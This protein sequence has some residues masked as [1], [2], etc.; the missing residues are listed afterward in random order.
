LKITPRNFCA[1]SI[2]VSLE[3]EG[4]AERCEAKTLTVHNEAAANQ[5]EE[6]GTQ[7]SFPGNVVIFENL[8]ACT[9]HKVML[10]VFLNKR[11]AT[12]I[13]SDFHFRPSV[14]SFH[15][16]PSY[17][18][19][20]K[21][22]FVQYDD[23]TRNFSWN[24][25]KFF[26]QTCAG[27]L[28]FTGVQMIR[29]GETEKYDGPDGSSDVVKDCNQEASLVVLFKEADEEKSVVALSQT[30]LRSSTPPE[31]ERVFVDENDILQIIRDPCLSSPSIKLVPNDNKLTPKRIP[32]EKP[33]KMSEVAWEGCIDYSVEVTRSETTNWPTLSH[34]GWKNLL[35]DWSLKVDAVDDKSITFRPLEK[36][37]EVETI[38]LEIDCDGRVHANKKFESNQWAEGLLVEQVISG[39]EY[40]CRARLLNTE[41]DKEVPG[42]WTKGT[43]VNTTEEVEVVKRGPMLTAGDTTGGEETGEKMDSAAKAQEGAAGVAPTA[44]GIGCIC[45]IVALAVLVVWR[46]MAGKKVEPNPLL[47]D[48]NDP[49]E[50]L[51]EVL[52][53]S[54]EEVKMVEEREPGSGSD[55]MKDVSDPIKSDP[56][57]DQHGSI[58]GALELNAPHVDAR[59]A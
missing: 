26:E 9:K 54:E 7:I 53:S 55:P 4:A 13:A 52:V 12:T 19:L 18:D 31:Q 30:V 29:D 15:T 34:P 35:A 1:R 11:E 45:V 49:D 8:Q 32:F 50:N 33:I 51:S 23:T 22:E 3:P 43:R 58:V 14:A 37:C 17:N 2:G 10:D 46:G 25:T 6:A 42:A 41:G 59:E 48:L 27:S 39:A 20:Q 16:L 56:I 5:S 40:E 57:K 21:N 24:F 28:E 44:I 38:K 47:E 36:A